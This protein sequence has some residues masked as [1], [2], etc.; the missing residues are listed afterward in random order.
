LYGD[1][2]AFEN[3]IFAARMYQVEHPIKKAQSSL[4][5]A[6]LGS[7]TSVRVARL[8][9]GARQRLAI[10]RAAIHQPLLVLLDEPFASLDTEGNK[11]LESLFQNWRNRK[12]TVC[13]VS[14]DIELSRRLAD[15]IIWLDSGHIRSIE[16]TNAFANSLRIA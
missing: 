7:L 14:H 6:G 9:Q 12:Q 11:W 4:L 3:L 16:H 8:S 1:L 5:D 2:T 15:R 10:V 13:F